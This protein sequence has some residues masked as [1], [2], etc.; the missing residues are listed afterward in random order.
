MSSAIKYYVDGAH[1][2]TATGGPEALIQL[3]LC[4]YALYPQRVHFP[5]THLTRVVDDP[6]TT[7]SFFHRRY[8]D[9]YPDVIKIPFSPSRVI[10]SKDIYIIPE[11]IACPRQLVDKGVRVYIYLLGPSKID[12]ASGCAYI[13]HNFWLSYH[14][15]VNLTRD[16]V[17]KPYISPSLVASA[18][19]A[20]AIMGNTQ[21]RKLVLL[22]DDNPKEII[23]YVGQCCV[24]LGCEA[25]V[26]Q[27]YARSELPELYTKSAV[28]VDWCMRG[29]ERMSLEAALHGVILVTANCQTGSDRRD[30]P[31]G[32][33]WVPDSSFPPT[34]DAN[35]NNSKLFR[36]LKRSL[37]SRTQALQEMSNLRNLYLKHVSSESM[38]R[39]V[40]ML[41]GRFENRHEE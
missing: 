23:T 16:S 32:N 1:T 14:A 26:V 25:L 8:I 11:V 15:N 18:H 6:A 27:G 31:I 12:K 36:I 30:I 5:Q 20:L 29:S 40:A 17:I 10:N 34:R 35:W 38:R 21:T 3:A 7:V 28:V 9:E 37:T 41:F 2:G 33:R 4:L 22:D 24:V 39:E 19:R 13:A